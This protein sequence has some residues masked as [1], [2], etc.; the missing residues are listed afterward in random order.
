[1]TPNTIHLAE[2][3]KALVAEA[4]RQAGVSLSDFGRSFLR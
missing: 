3:T 2:T 1:M 4:P